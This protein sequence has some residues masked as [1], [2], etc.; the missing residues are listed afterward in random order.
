MPRSTVG[1]VTIVVL[2]MNHPEQLGLRT[3]LVREGKLKLDEG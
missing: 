1:Q 3:S 2:A